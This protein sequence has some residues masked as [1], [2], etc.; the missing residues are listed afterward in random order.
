[1][2]VCLLHDKRPLLGENETDPSPQQWGGDGENEGIRKKLESL[3]RQE[4]RQTQTQ[5]TKKTQN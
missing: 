3:L 2:S 5:E 4:N 1:M